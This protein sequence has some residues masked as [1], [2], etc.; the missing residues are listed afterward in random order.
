M[1]GEALCLEDPPEARGAAWMRPFGHWQALP[2]GR[3]AVTQNGADWQ[4]YD[5]GHLARVAGQLAH[6]RCAEPTKILRRRYRNPMRS[7]SEAEQRKKLRT[8]ISALERIRDVVKR[9]NALSAEVVAESAVDV[10]APKGRQED[11][12]SSSRS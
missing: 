6:L 1:Q 4:V 7:L 5:Y 10:T 9:Q 8:L 12:E 3:T 11:P 2:S